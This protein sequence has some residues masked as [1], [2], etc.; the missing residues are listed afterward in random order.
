MVYRPR[1]VVAAANRY[2]RSDLGDVERL[3]NAWEARRSKP[4]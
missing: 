4:Y 1:T 3:I 2:V